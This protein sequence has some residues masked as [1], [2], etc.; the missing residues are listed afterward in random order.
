MNRIKLSH[1]EF[2]QIPIKNRHGIYETEYLTIY[3]VN[4]KCH[5]TDG[6][7]IEYSNGKKFWYINGTQYTEDEYNTQIYLY[8]NNLLNY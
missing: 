7:A 8:N 2:L 4:G 6:P 5:R 3:C 1:N